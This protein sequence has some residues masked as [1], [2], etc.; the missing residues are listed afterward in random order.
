MSTYTV[1]ICR[2]VIYEY[3]VPASRWGEAVQAGLDEHDRRYPDDE[4]WRRYAESA[5]QVG[6][7]AGE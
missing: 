3:T 4:K 7:P 2:E 6:D 1:K 5:E